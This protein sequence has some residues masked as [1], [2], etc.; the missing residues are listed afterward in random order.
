MRK[1]NCIVPYEASVS[2]RFAQCKDQHAL[3][4]LGNCLGTKS[5]P[6]MV[7]A[8]SVTFPAVFR[9]LFTVYHLITEPMTAFS[10][11][12]KVSLMKNFIVC[13]NLVAWFFRLQKF[14][15]DN[16]IWRLDILYFQWILLVLHWK[17]CSIEASKRN[18]SSSLLFDYRSKE[19]EQIQCSTAALSG[20]GIQAIITEYLIMYADVLFSDSTGNSG[21]L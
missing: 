3:Q 11:I 8:F 2:H 9:H 10:F 4:E 17:L 14:V 21:A 20:V 18:W 13:L 1:Q 15:K 12:S 16:F 5:I 19:L 7:F 6:V